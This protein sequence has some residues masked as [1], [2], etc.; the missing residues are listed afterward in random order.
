MN[1]TKDLRDINHFY[2]C[3]IVALRLRKNCIPIETESQRKRFIIN[4]LY[5]AQKQ[6]AFSRITHAEILWLVE[7]F[8]R[9]NKSSGK[10]V[11]MLNLSPVLTDSSRWQSYSS[12]KRR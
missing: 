9:I 8:M 11:F 5:T 4:W 7:E 12:L 6:K 3:L 2:Y 1:L 10:P